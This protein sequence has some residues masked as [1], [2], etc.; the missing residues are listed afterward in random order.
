VQINH[1]L[2]WGTL[3][4]SLGCAPDK[5]APSTSP[6]PAVNADKESQ[7]SDAAGR[8][9][10]DPALHE[11]I[12]AAFDRHRVKPAA[13][14]VY[15]ALAHLE[16]TFSVDVVSP[17]GAVG[18]YQITPVT[19]N[20]ILDDHPDY[21]RR[22]AP[23]FNPLYRGKRRVLHRGADR[24]YP[25]R[26]MRIY[27]GHLK[28][29]RRE[30]R[31]RFPSDHDRYLEALKTVDI[32][33]DPH[34]NAMMAVFHLERIRKK[35]F[36]HYRCYRYRGRDPEHRGKKLCGSFTGRHATLL[37]AAGYHLG[38]GAVEN[39]LALSR[40]RS[41]RS[42]LKSVRRSPSG[43]YKRNHFYLMKLLRLSRKYSAVLEGEKL[44]KES[45][46]KVFPRQPAIARRLFRTYHVGPPQLRSN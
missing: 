25:L 11:I 22:Q 35:S 37:A 43:A 38:L 6:P 36:S 21:D 3:S 27:A 2:L 42:Y 44:T 20:W 5:R 23:I 1:L 46:L 15:L 30:Q 9:A 10:S 14:P 31:R 19:A 39:M 29:S 34:A 26:V 40:A 41:I 16:S 45:V 33:F 7:G 4:L 12:L 24:V 32:R 13:R 18:L 28:R 17:V 8:R